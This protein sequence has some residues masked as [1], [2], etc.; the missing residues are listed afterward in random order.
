MFGLQLRSR[1]NIEG[2]FP[3][4]SSVTL[5]FLPTATF[6]PAYLPSLLERRVLATGD[7]VCVVPK[8]SHWRANATRC[9]CKK[10]GRRNLVHSF[11]RSLVG[12]MQYSRSQTSCVYH[13]TRPG[14]TLYAPVRSSLPK[15]FSTVPLSLRC[16]FWV[17]SMVGPRRSVNAHR[18][19]HWLP[20]HRRA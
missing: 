2:R 17:R 5:A 18:S 1:A 13:A 9:K 10:W 15:V 3:H 11:I 4:M 20:R 12:T 8:R 6:G 7:M 16:R 19:N 14:Y